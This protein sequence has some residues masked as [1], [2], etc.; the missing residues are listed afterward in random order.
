MLPLWESSATRPAGSGFEAS[1][2]AVLESSTPRQFGPRRTAPAARTRST[3]RS[4]TAF[5]AAPSSAKPAV[6]RRSRWRLPRGVVHGLLETLRR[7]GDDDEIDSFV[8]FRQAPERGVS[9]DALA[10][11]VDEVDRPAARHAESLD[12]DPV[13]VLRLVVAGTED[14]DRPGIEQ[15]REVAVDDRAHRVSSTFGAG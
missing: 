3:T 12:A 11:P 15:R 8:E 13:A 5:P 9:Q 10:A 7:D 14:G 1:V 2:S 6:T 4:C